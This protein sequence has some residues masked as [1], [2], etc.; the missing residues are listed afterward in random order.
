MLMQSPASCGSLRW[1]TT[2]L[3]RFWDW[4]DKE[5][6]DRGT[7]YRGVERDGG[8]TNGVVSRPARLRTR[9]T[10]KAIETIARAFGVGN[11][12]VL[13]EAGIIADMASGEISLREW[14]ELGAML[15]EED[16]RKA[17]EVIRTLFAKG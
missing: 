2:R 9:P 15:T 5:I 8:A 11:V 10:L 1:M 16:R 6:V 7:T 3:E 4:V 17:G 12:R 13:E 14:H